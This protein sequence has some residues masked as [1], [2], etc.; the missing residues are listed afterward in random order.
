MWTQNPTVRDVYSWT[1]FPERVACFRCNPTN[2]VPISKRTTVKSWNARLYQ[3]SSFFLH[4]GHGYLLCVWS[5]AFVYAFLHSFSISVYREP[6]S[7]KVVRASHS[8][9]QA[10]CWSKPTWWSQTVTVEDAKLYQK[11][12]LFYMWTHVLFMRWSSAFRNAEGTS[13][14]LLICA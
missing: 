7:P 4:S 10:T 2:H 13:L 3:K 6:I 1:Y 14:R 11:W 12:V 9:P 8:I 5:S